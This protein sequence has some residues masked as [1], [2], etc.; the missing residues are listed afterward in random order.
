MLHI[1]PRLRRSSVHPLGIFW[2]LCFKISWLRAKIKHQQTHN[3]NLFTLFHLAGSI[4]TGDNDGETNR[5]SSNGLFTWDL[6]F[7][8]RLSVEKCVDDASF[9]D[10]FFGQKFDDFKKHGLVKKTDFFFTDT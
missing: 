10:F 1:R 9:F 2:A 7:F 8:T 3:K 4:H 5:P 6:R